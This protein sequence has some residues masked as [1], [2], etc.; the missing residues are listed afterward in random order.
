MIPG[1]QGTAA[2]AAA[3]LIHFVGIK[4]DPVLD[5]VIQNPSGFFKIA[6]AESFLSP[7]S[8]I[9][10]IM[11][12]GAL[13]KFRFIQSNTTVFDICYQQIENRHELKLF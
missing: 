2:P 9:A 1:G 12:G 3:D 6:V 8:I 10:W 5:A 11:I 4:I 13:G 7:S